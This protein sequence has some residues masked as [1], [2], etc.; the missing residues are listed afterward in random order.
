MKSAAGKEL[1]IVM[2]PY[3]RELYKDAVNSLHI[4]LNS[5]NIIE[6]N[7]YSGLFDFSHL[8]DFYR[9]LEEVDENK[10]VSFSI[11][12]WRMIYTALSL[13]CVVFSKRSLGKMRSEVYVHPERGTEQELEQ[14]HE[15]TPKVRRIVQDLEKRLSHLPI[16]RQRMDELQRRGWPQ[17]MDALPKYNVLK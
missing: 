10:D 14:I 1:K 7:F 12:E 4:F 3:I 16:F 8:M 2:Q 11:V 9:R 13:Y 5:D 17:L 6:N 15:R